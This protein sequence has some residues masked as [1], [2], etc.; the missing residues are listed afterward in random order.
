MPTSRRGVGLLAL[1]GVAAFV[2]AFLGAMGFRGNPPVEPSGLPGTLGP[3]V[4]LAPGATPLVRIDPSLLSVLPDNVAGFSVLENREGDAD[5]EANASLASLADAAVGALAIDPGPGDFVYALVV[6][7][8]P[9]ALDEDGFRNWRD[10]YDQGACGG[11]GVGGHAQ[12]EIGGRTVYVGTC[13]N[14]LH[15]Y[16]AWIGDRNLLISASSAGTREFGRE[17]FANLRPD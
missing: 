12:S 1:V 16:H 5:A 13:V 2:G 11:S 7:L 9:G 17:L 8:T 6:R 14:G 3:P 10:A 15:T 4:T